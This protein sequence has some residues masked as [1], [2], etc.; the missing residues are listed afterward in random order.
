MVQRKS[1]AL[2]YLLLSLALLSAVE[3]EVTDSQASDLMELIDMPASA[4]SDTLTLPTEDSFL[5]EKDIIE[6]LDLQDLIDRIDRY[7][8]ETYPNS[9]Y[10]E[11]ISTPS[12]AT[13]YRLGFDFAGL[14]NEPRDLMSSGFAIPG[15]FFQSWIYQGYFSQF[16]TLHHDAWGMD[17]N[18]E[19][20]DYPVSL[21]R[22]EGSLGDYDSRYALAGFA[23]A[24]LF[25]ISGSSMRF[26][27]TLFNGYWV[28]SPNSGNSIKQFLSYRYQDFLFSLDMASYHKDGGSYELKP[29]YWHLGNFRYEHDVTQLIAK[30]EHKLLSLSVASMKDEMSFP[31]QNRSWK[32]KSLHLAAHRV[33]SIP[34][35]NARLRYEYRDLDRDYEP[36]RGY[37]FADFKEELSL[38]IAHKSVLGIKADARI[39]DWDFWQTKLDLYRDLGIWRLGLES[40]LTKGYTRLNIAHSPTDG[41]MIPVA[42]LYIPQEHGLY[43]MVSL[44]DLRIKASLAQKEEKQYSSVSEVSKKL[45]LVRL[46]GRY[47]A[48][49]NDW[50]LRVDTGWRYQEYD[51]ALMAAPEYSFSSEHRLFRNLSHDNRLELGFAIS[52]HTDYYLPNAVNPYL[53]EAS[54]ILDAWAAVRISKLFDFS[55]T[56]KNIMSTSIYGLY[57]IPLSVHANLRWFFIN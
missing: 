36:A 55:V 11:P 39:K 30:V 27:Y 53:I 31:A 34:G 6:E 3:P 49:W 52:G 54:T 45:M 10:F 8:Q 56:G 5:S 15:T 35:G 12:S 1:L 16:H 4:E 50:Q 38:S 32:S 28:D 40:A 18:P 44:G 46:G 17:A 41:S 51:P 9:R 43:G 24:D 29:A 42:D 2:I 14:Q 20:Y 21:S 25:G 13:S 19:I 23:K 22:L 47:E 48:R 33:L 7:R 57:P 37:N 26:D